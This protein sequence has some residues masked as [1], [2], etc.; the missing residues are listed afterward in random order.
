MS[1]ESKDL[2]QI[3]ALGDLTLWEENGLIWGMLV[4]ETDRHHGVGATASVTL[5]AIQDRIG[6]SRD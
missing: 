6:E 3:V 1:I 4:T 5:R 2:D